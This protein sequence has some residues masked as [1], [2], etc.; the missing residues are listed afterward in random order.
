[1]ATLRS[2]PSLLVDRDAELAA[3]EGY[4]RQLI[5]STTPPRDLKWKPTVVGPTWQWTEEHGWNL[6]ESTLGWEQLAWAGY[7][8]QNPR[9]GPW[10][11]T[12]EQA[13][14]ILWLYALDESGAFQYSTAALQRLKGWGKDPVGATVSAI[15]MLAPCRF[16]GWDGDRP[17]GRE[18]PNA[19]IQVIGVAEDQTKNTMKFLPGILP[20]ET[21]RHYGLQ[22]GKLTAWALGDTRQIEA[23]TSSPGTLEGGRPT[24]LLMNEI[25]NWNSS[26]GGHDL[27]G[28]LEGNAAKRDAD[29]P[30]KMLAIFNAYRP[31]EDS[32]AERMRDAYEKSQGNPD[33]E[34]E[35]DRPSFMDFGLLYDSLEAPPEAPLTI[36]AAPEVVA[37]VRGDSHWLDITRILKSIANPQNPPSESRRKWY[38]QITAAEDAW[39]TP[40]AW[41]Q[42]ARPDVVVEKREEIAMFLDCSLSDDGT[43]LVG[44]RVSD[45]H[46]FVLGYWQRPVSVKKDPSWRVSRDKVDA[47]VE[48]AFAKYTVI[49]FYGDP[50]HVLDPETRD[51][52]WDSYF[53]TW[54]ERYKA[55]LRVWARR[56]H[57]AGHAV[58]FDMSQIAVQ[59][60]FVAALERADADIEQKAFTHDG[61][62]RLRRHVLNARLV[63]TRAGRSIAKEHRES[64]K[65]IDLAVAFVGARMVRQ[66]YINTRKRRGG[67]VW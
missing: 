51:R 37:A 17:I 18:E 27:W 52:Y 36:Q 7:W 8:L 15:E 49:G 59:K 62:A 66:A 60:T 11:Y 53:D 3:I 58:M 45:G 16:A 61:D 1:M 30:A 43:A 44:C 14:F 63:P 9:G 31:G 33:A 42:L 22:L 40:Q 21:R 46:I 6:P 32:V 41:D 39:Q 29:S 48:S 5:A 38:N 65:K 25:Q 10:I 20:R 23:V 2:A 56:G 34:D 24:F 54:H 67:R 26:T 57:D 55:K 4:Y 64:P 12:P 50:S 19:W 13:R 28:A 47:A 35:D